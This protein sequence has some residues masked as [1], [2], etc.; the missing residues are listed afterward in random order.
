MNLLTMP[1]SK[2]ATLRNQVA[3][4]LARR[5][6]AAVNGH[7]AAAIIYGNE[8]AKRALVVAAAGG[9]SILFVGPPNCGKTM[10]R[11]VAL[12]LGLTETFEGRPCPCGWRSHRDHPCTCSAKQVQRHM[13]KLPLADITIEMH[14]P[15]SRDRIM[16]GSSLAE[17]RQYI[18]NTTDDESLDLEETASRLLR[19][20]VQEMGL[21]EAVRQRI[22]QV[23]RTI[24]NLDRVEH[25]HSAHVC[26]AVNYRLLRR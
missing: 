18:A 7:D 19:A 4:E 25:I 8:A 9:H 1:D 22:V 20:S 3:D 2:L 14:Q 5:T 21:D 12:E 16:P 17:M 10:M 13:A 26:E 6:K 15:E 11:A 24:A 23:A